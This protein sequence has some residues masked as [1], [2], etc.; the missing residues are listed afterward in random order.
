MK[1]N[2][3][4]ENDNKE[5][6]GTCILLCAPPVFGVLDRYRRFSILQQHRF[7]LDHRSNHKNLRPVTIWRRQ[8]ASSYASSFGGG[9]QNYSHTPCTPLPSSICLTPNTN[10]ENVS[11]G[12]YYFSEISILRHF[13]PF[14]LGIRWEKAIFW[15]YIYQNSSKIGNTQH[16]SLINSCDLN[17]LAR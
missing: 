1:E 13:Q 2:N 11:V 7:V 8:E 12:S 5:N 15:C 3:K 14:L 6:R 17:I 9:S 10:Q 4:E 16:T